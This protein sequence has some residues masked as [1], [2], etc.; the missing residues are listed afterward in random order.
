M[1]YHFTHDVVTFH[2]N[3]GISIIMLSSLRLPLI[4]CTANCGALPDP[5]N[6]NVIITGTLQGAVATY[7]CDLGLELVGNGTRECGD[8]M[9]WLG[10]AP[11]C[12]GRQY[13]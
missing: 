1:R 5:A 8:N 2:G 10:S 9:R 12:S 13:F 4:R 11:T 7:T 6:G 3:S